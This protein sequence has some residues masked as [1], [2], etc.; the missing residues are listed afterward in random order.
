MGA[1]VGKTEAQVKS[2]GTEYRVGQVPFAA[3]GRAKALA[4]QGGFV[5]MIADAN[6]D[7]ILGVHMIGP[8]VSELVQEMVVAMEYKAS[9][10]DIARIIHGH[11]TLGETVHE[12]ALA[13]D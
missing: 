6:T 4:Q 2:A 1:W 10:E 13:V 9:S 3:N 11:P 12:T 8:Y 7:E 5:K